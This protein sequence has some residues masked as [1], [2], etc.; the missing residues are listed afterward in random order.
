MGMGQNFNSMAILNPF[1]S[2]GFSHNYQLDESI[3]NLKVVGEYVSNPF[4][5]LK[6]ILQGN[7]GDPDQTVCQCPTNRTLDLYGLI[8]K[9]SFPAVKLINSLIRGGLNY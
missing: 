2:N 9:G 4:K 3:S 6:Y 5:F 7:S 1:M 8:K